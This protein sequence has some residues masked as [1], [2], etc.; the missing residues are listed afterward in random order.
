MSS[1]DGW[2]LMYLLTAP[3]NTLL[4][5]VTRQQTPTSDSRGIDDKVMRTDKQKSSSVPVI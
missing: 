5:A 4:I 1:H 3:L 2:Y